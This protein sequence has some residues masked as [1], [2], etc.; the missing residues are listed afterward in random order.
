M[1]GSRK[2]VGHVWDLVL[3]SGAE[4]LVLPFCSSKDDGGCRSVNIQDRDIGG[5]VN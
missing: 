3:G 1:A 5:E 2:R 4:L